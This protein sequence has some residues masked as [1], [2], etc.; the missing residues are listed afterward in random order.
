MKVQ[1]SYDEKRKR[2]VFRFVGTRK[3]IS[4]IEVHSGSMVRYFRPDFLGVHLESEVTNEGVA[5]S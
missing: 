4:F 1:V 5:D 2:L 3:A